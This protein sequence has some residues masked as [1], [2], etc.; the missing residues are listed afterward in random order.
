M[1]VWVCFP[2]E[3]TFD[4]ECNN[5]ITRLDIADFGVQSLEMAGVGTDVLHQLSSVCV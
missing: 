1:I 2:A 5:E 4:L 3:V